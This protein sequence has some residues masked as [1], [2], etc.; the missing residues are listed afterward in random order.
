MCEEVF[1][2]YAFI[3]ARRESDDA[4]ALNWPGTA[5]K[6]E[7]AG[8]PSQ[9]QRCLPGGQASLSGPALLAAGGGGGSG[10]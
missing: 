3:N 10:H 5:V 9:P 8:R 6:N 2:V 4:A 1:A 7:P